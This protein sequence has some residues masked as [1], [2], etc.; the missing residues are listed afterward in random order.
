[1]SASS[2]PRV[3]EANPRSSA[4]KGVKR[5]P[6]GVTELVHPSLTRKEAAA[7]LVSDKRDELVSGAQLVTFRRPTLSVRAIK[8][9]DDASLQWRTLWPI[10]RIGSYTGAPNR[11]GG[12]VVEQDGSRRTLE[13]E[14]ALERAHVRE[15]HFNG[16]VQWMLTQPFLLRWPV[17]ERCIWHIPDMLFLDANGWSAADVKPDDVRTPEND[18]V[19]ELTANTVAMLDLD[20]RVLGSIS[21][22][23][24]QNLR[25]LA[26]QRWAP[27]ANNPVL[28]AA[29]VAARSA[30][31]SSLG[32]V[33]DS[34][35]GGPLGAW[36]A[37][38]LLTR[39]LQAD[40]DAPL[41]FGSAVS[42][43]A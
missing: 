2:H 29:L 18:A 24:R 17:G 4:R 33:I 23:R 8:D 16:G 11:I 15:R 43:D 22:Q 35:G 37:L 34:A 20:F 36:A 30:R 27:D 7:L 9:I 41:T 13:V 40:L 32:G 3:H 25:T 31:C 38:H 19:F 14:S 1:M 21:P 28:H 6:A 5:Y 39:E 42:W 10:R 26:S 12:C